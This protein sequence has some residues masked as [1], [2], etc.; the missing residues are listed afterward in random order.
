MWM[1]ECKERDGGGEAEGRTGGKEGRTDERQ[2][3]IGMRG[4][5]HHL[6]DLDLTPSGSIRLEMKK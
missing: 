5:G 1:R 6:Q 3:E 2:E 4:L